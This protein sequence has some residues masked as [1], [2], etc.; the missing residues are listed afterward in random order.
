[1]KNCRKLLALILAM[2]MVLSLASCG[3]EK[4][5]P[6]S[7]PSSGS[8]SIIGNA[9][10]VDQAAVAAGEPDGIV[11]GSVLNTVFTGITSGTTPNT[12]N[13]NG[14]ITLCQNVY[15]T[16]FYPAN[17][18]YGDMRNLLAKD[19]QVSEDGLTWTIHL[20][21][22][23]YFSNG[24]HFTSE[25]VIASWNH[26]YE[27]YP[28]DFDMMKSW[29][30]NGE[31][32][33]VIELNRVV[34]DLDKQLSHITWSILDHKLLEQYPDDGNLDIAIGTGPYMIK[35]YN[36]GQNIVLVANPEYWNEERFP[37]IETVNIHM[38]SD[39][40]SAWISFQNGDLDVS[41]ELSTIQ[42]TSLVG[43]SKFNLYEFQTA[44]TESLWF[45]AAAAPFD[46]EAVREALSYL[47]DKEQVNLAATDGTGNV[48]YSP[49]S[50]VSPLY[51]TKEELGDAAREYNTEKGLA[52]LSE[53]GYQPSDI[54]FEILVPTSSNVEQLMAENIQAQL[55]AL[56]LDVKVAAYERA[57]Y[58]TLIQTSDYQC[59]IHT[60]AATLFGGDNVINNTF[61]SSGRN[62]F[63][64]WSVKDPDYGAYLDNLISEARSL[65]NYDE[66]SAA[67]N[68][69]T[70]E[71]MEKSACVPIL[72]SIKF[73][74]YSSDLAG[75]I[76]SQKEETLWFYECYWAQ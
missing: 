20:V 44:S 68:A 52:I 14:C 61:G 28:G 1:M 49:F 64:N 71:M 40:N 54:S 8:N 22:D 12:S 74:A 66:Q 69:I 13:D 65:S 35:E 21:E 73:F 48:E 6:D 11:A 58:M 70:V 27:L 38:I 59:A 29:S 33:I 7:A 37:H 76:F 45:N 25:D 57:T 41:P 75:L 60:A 18:D 32:E 47:I 63:N 15:E 2:L 51:V 72:N 34:S 42:Y 10:E 43:D 4:S 9:T 5:T 16:L 56:G 46:D 50:P 53:A 19:V 3:G 67:L 17:G 62:H 26:R 23:A 31:F 39:G 24:D 36:A 55:L 30:A